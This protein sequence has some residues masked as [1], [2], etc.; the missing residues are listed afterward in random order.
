MYGRGGEA[1]PPIRTGDSGVKHV[2]AIM[3]L[4]KARVDS[5]KSAF[6]KGTDLLSGWE[7]S[8]KRTCN[9]NK[10]PTVSL[11]LNLQGCFVLWRV[12]PGGD[13]RM[14]WKHPAVASAQ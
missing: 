9:R 5:R 6:N 1:A 13:G 14:G 12:Y 2:D 3:G 7:N 10:N 4:T 11:F 8:C